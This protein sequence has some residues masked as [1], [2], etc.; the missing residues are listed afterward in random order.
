MPGDPHWNQPGGPFHA[1]SHPAIAGRERELR[2]LSD[3]V[4]RLIRVTT[5]S[6][7]DAAWTARAAEQV[8]ALA[9]TLEPAQGGAA[10]ARYNIS[11]APEDPHDVFPYDVMLGLYNPIAP[12]IAVD[13]QPPRALGRVVFD[14][15]YEG[16]P[17]CVHGA[18]LAAAFDQVINVANIFSGNAGPTAR[19]ELTYKRPTPLHAELHFEGW[20]ESRDGR[21][22]TSRALVR[23][24]GEVTAEAEGLFIAIDLERV[25]KMG[26]AED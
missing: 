5:N 16:P 9:E 8:A 20:V 1:S 13:W 12:P 4:R 23:H 17:G 11:R 14:D 24:D 19:L 3:A 18:I 21:K 6:Q 25:M 26:E 15:P 10:P 2:A 22:V 7:A